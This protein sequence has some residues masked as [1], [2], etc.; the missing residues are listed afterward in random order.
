MLDLQQMLPGQ[1]LKVIFYHIYWPLFSLIYWID[2]DLEK[3][4]QPHLS[5]TLDLHT[6]SAVQ[7]L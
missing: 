7:K 5:S 1:L 4:C 2:C 6:Y 3:K